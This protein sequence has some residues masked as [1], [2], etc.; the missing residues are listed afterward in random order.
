MATNN[1]NI[2]DVTKRPGIIISEID[3]SVR[4]I[5]A[6]TTLINLVP[7]FSRKGPVNRPVLISTPQDLSDIFGDID[8]FLEKKGCFFHRT[9]L[10]ILPSGP[11]WALNLLETDDT[12][13]L[14]EWKTVSVASDK[15]NEP[16][17]KSPYSHFFNRSDFWYRDTEAFLTLAK[18]NSD[19]STNILHITNMSD[20]KV[21]VF[22]YKSSANGYSDTLETWYGGKTNVPAYLHPA[23]LAS[24]YLVSMLIVSGDWSNYKALS[25]DA[26]WSKYFTPNGL[27]TTQINNFRNDASV[28]QLKFYSDLSLI[29][30]FKSEP[31]NPNGRD[32]FIETVVNRDTDTTGVFISYDIDQLESS[33]FSMGL[34]D[35]IGSNLV[36]SDTEIVNYLSYNETI[37]ENLTFNEQVLDRAGNSF[38]NEGLNIEGKLLSSLSFTDF[39]I[40]PGAG[41]SDI[42]LIPTT[43]KYI[44]SGVQILALNNT[45]NVPDVAI[46][47]I[48]KDTLYLDANGN[49]GV[50][51][52]FSVSNQTQW[53]DV[54][55]IPLASG[56]LPLAI[57]YVGDQGTNGG[58]GISAPIQVLPFIDFAVSNGTNSADI[59]I[60]YTGN[61]SIEFLFTGTKSSD[62]DIN[63]RKTRLNAIFNQIQA[64]L[65]IG[66]SI[67]KS[68]TNDKIIITDATLVTAADENKALTVTV[69]PS[70]NIN[71]SSFGTPEIYFIDDELTFRST[72]GSPAGTKTEPSA[73]TSGY[74]VASLHSTL[75]QSFN[76]GFINSGDFFYPNLFNHVFPDAD[77][78]V[79]GGNDVIS[80]YFNTADNIV[81]SLMTGKIRIF[82]TKAND[83]VYTV[84]NL[85][86]TDSIITSQPLF[87]GLY[88]LKLDIIVNEA[89]S[90]ETVSAGDITVHG[91]NDSDITYLRMFFVGSNLTVQYADK[92]L[93]PVTISDTYNLSSI[94]VFSKRNNYKE[95]VE[96]ETVLATNK[97]LVNASRFIGVK[98]GDYLQAFVDDSSLQPGEVG[99]RLT[100]I[101]SK[102]TSASDAT[103]VEITT[104]AQIDVI[105]FGAELQTY[106]YT[107]VENYVNTYSAIV[108]S[109]FKMRADSLPNNTE[110]RQNSILNVLASGTS[111]FKGLVNRNKITW[112][113][114]VDPWANGLTANSKQQFMDLCAERLT[115]LG[116]LNM[117]SA[118]SFK[119]STDTSF[120][121]PDG[122]LN[123][124]FIRQ[125]GDPESNPSFLYTFGQGVGQS[126][127]A[128]FFPFVTIDDNG[129]PIDMPPASFVANTFMRKHTS[130]LASVNPWTVAAGLTNGFLSGFG[131]VEIDLTPDDITSLNLMNANP[132]VYKMNRGFVIETDNTAQLSPRSALSF[133]HVREV[134][135]ELEEQLYQMLLTYQWRFNTS[136]VRDEIK[137]KADAICEN[138][139]RNNGLFDFFN[140]CDETNNT[141]EIIDAQIGILE[142]FV[143]PVKAMGVIVNNIT[144]LKTG[145]IQAGGFR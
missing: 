78:S 114:L 61:N 14:L 37:T 69:S 89:V 46:G 16:V 91:A 53:N 3:Q 70:L 140:V 123:V 4:Q 50:A 24:D 21:S 139:V 12:L 84:L 40:T 7:G 135:I 48:R 75:Y 107:S 111:I 108:L 28:T 113:Y 131:N 136:D 32:V 56:V 65:K 11:V 141:P 77:F 92:F 134:L 72:S 6:Q 85:S 81:Y 129:R 100:R 13:D 34:L 119:N 8:R 117:P 9:I 29:P 86:I 83:G 25:V 95:S 127:V 121:N 30:Y 2:A 79:V 126:N 106:R 52:G 43:L 128:Y 145:T 23:D 44:L 10:N 31:N 5:P 76:S 125:G 62:A 87:K 15:L 55:L 80:L 115:C 133:T 97:I 33:D 51:Q 20:R 82:G 35:L 68:T 41:S 1:I 88:N 103:L 57:V 118:K 71:D 47:K 63:Y 143:E 144:I 67:I 104:D 124:D 96:I 45:V 73:S 105:S 116:L 64:K 137:S 66:T 94:K 90:V 26:R 120:L 93:N 36:D 109:G 38:G 99:K 17:K 112:R 22:I 19:D 39:L 74:G 98:I 18:N 102:K 54:P 60:T 110:E 130:R 142:S 132:I 101:V 49:L 59:L 27:R 138:F 42:N 58:L 122:T